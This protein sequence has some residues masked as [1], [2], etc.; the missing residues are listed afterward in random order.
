MSQAWLTKKGDTHKFQ[1]VS[2]TPFF[3]GT[4]IVCVPIFTPKRPLA[5]SIS[6]AGRLGGLAFNRRRQSSGIH[7]AD[8]AERD[9]EALFWPAMAIFAAG[10]LLFGWPWLSGR[11]MIPWDAKA[12]FL[13]QVQFLASSIWRGE[14]PFWTPNVFGGHPQIAD[15]QSQIFSPPMLLLALLDPTPGNHAADVTVMLCLLGAG[16]GVIWLFRELG[17]HPAGGLVAALGYAFG[18]AMAWRLQHF[19]P[20]MGLAYLPFAI[21]FLRRALERQSI[22]WGFAAGITAG[23]IVCGRDQISLLVVYMLATWVIAWLASRPDPKEAILD[24]LQPLAA[25]AAGG[26]IVALVPVVL[27]ALLAGQSN[28]PEIDFIG[29]GRGSLHPA[30]LL[31]AFSPHLYGAAG[32]MADFWGPPSYHW[33]GTDLFTAQNVGQSYIGALPIALLIAGFVRGDLWNREIRFYAIAFLLVLLYALGWY[34][35]FFRAAYELIPGVS[36]YRR[37]ADAV[38]LI[39]C[40]GSILAGYTFHRIIAAPYGETWWLRAAIT[41]GI[42]AAMLLACLAVARMMDR[43]VMATEPMLW[44]VASF[45]VATAA[46][47]AAAH[48]RPLRPIAALA[49]LGGAVAADLAWNNGP[50]GASGLPPDMV[51]ML[52][53]DTKNETVALLKRLTAEGRT[54]TRRDRVELA[55]LGFNWPNASL[56][57]GLDNTL[58]YNPIRLGIYTD[59]TGA[60]DHSGMPDQRRFSALMPSYRSRL[61]DMLGLRWIA[62]GVPIEQLDKRL[63]K[64]AFPLVARTRDGFVYENPNAMPRVMFARRAVPYNLDQLIASGVWPDLDPA[65]TVLVDDAVVPPPRI[66]GSLPPLLGAGTARILSYANNEVLIEADSPQGGW[67]VLNDTWHPRWEVEIDG[68]NTGPSVRANAIFRAVAVP[69]GK[70]RVRFIFRPLSGSWSA[71]RRPASAP[72]GYSA[73]MRRASR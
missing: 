69:P 32:P 61:A 50:N 59:A 55:G 16:L 31:T 30:L 17:W 58:G 9:G 14:L 44:A 49:V 66:P 12:H 19:G 57:H 4:V 34:T 28:R 38:F 63:P 41:V 62:T 53:P 15:P 40:L 35:P 72:D 26:L 36:L 3:D 70:V 39:G 71:P 23:F 68:R 54:D 1:R 6:P 5:M 42:I 8:P 47:G 11:V 65:D 60:E 10:W 25:G 48:L 21:I 52:E 56:T 29:A 45:A 2:A 18:A 67:V 13:P 7:L 64:D 22:G 46:L 73:D 27:T 20:V 24:S 51:E 43:T 37:P 33:P